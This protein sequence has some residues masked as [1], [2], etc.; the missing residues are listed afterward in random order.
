MIEIV[1]L[2][3]PER[4]AAFSKS[5]AP[6]WVAPMTKTPSKVL[7]PSSSAKNEFTICCLALLITEPSKGDVIS[8]SISSKNTKHGASRRASSKRILMWPGFA[9]SEAQSGANIG[10]P[11]A[12]AKCRA[13]SVFPGPGGP[14]SI[15]PFGICAPKLR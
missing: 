5:L 15:T 4:I 13:K 9:A 12:L 7:T 8:A 6:R 14:S 1:S 11:I 10:A 2:S 3:L